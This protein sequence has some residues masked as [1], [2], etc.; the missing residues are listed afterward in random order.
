M[1]IRNLWAFQAS[2]K[3]GFMELKGVTSVSRKLRSFMLHGTHRS[4]PSRR[5]T[6]YYGV[7]LVQ[8]KAWS[9]IQTLPRLEVVTQIIANTKYKIY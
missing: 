1:V 4:Y 2:F 7:Y 3:A 5:R 9:N 8:M 6:R